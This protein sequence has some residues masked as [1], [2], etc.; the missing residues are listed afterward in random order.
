[1]SQVRWVEV[2]HDDNDIRLDRWFKRHYPM[3]KHGQLEKL[4]RSKQIKVDNKKAQ[5][6]QR[7]CTGQTIRIPPLPMDTDPVK[8]S[9][10]NQA[11][12]QQQDQ[13]YLQSLTLYEDE[14]LLAINKPYGLAVQ[15]G[16]GINRS[17]DSL[18]NALSEQ[19]PMRPKLVHR[20]DKYTSGVLLLAKTNQSATYLT[21]L[22]RHKAIH[23]QYSA[24][25]VGAVS[26]ATGIID[27]PIT[28]GTI[29]RD[30]ELMVVNQQ[31]GDMAITDY[32]VK[33]TVGRKL[34]WLILYPK[35]GRK[36]QL[37][38]HCA[39]L[40]H[41]IIGDKKY[42]GEEA[43]MEG[44]NRKMHLHAQRITIKDFFGKSLTVE[45]PMPKHMQQSFELLGLAP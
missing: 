26:P 42:G 31:Y 8:Q 2:H 18:L 40:G 16:S 45:A 21:E 4:L 30:K 5:S 27:A 38:V 9:S 12:H 35:T 34:S 13:E 33:E 24:L 20:L 1:M 44:L 17:V 19:Y 6:N 39:A 43:M 11:K 25:V 37:R 15:G 28:K 7:L 29:G 23:K 3:V 22:F 41:P 36:H 32:T 14:H 10:T